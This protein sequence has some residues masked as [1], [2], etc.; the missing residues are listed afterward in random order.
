M[1]SICDG[2]KP[3]DLLPGEGHCGLV[4]AEVMEE[5]WD[6]LECL[7]SP[8]HVDTLRTWRDGIRTGDLCRVMSSVLMNWINALV[9]V[10]RK[11]CLLSP[12]TMWG[13]S[14]MT[15]LVNQGGRFLPDT[16]STNIWSCIPGPKTVR[17]KF[18]AYKRLSWRCFIQRSEGT[19]T[20]QPSGIPDGYLLM[21]KKFKTYHDSN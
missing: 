7:L 14:K 2:W 15:Q 10:V 21:K 6:R 16:E 9:K 13:H 3:D 20:R 19:K 17:N 4:L 5:N 12:F 8:N 1:F 11:T 18:V